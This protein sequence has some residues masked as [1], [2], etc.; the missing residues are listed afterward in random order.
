VRIGDT[1]MQT[2]TVRN[3]GNGPIRF[4]EVMVTDPGFATGASTCARLAPQEMCT[5]N[6]L[7][8]PTSAGEMVGY[9]RFTSNRGVDSVGL[10]GRGVKKRQHLSQKL[11]KR[12]KVLGLTPLTPANART[13]AGQP[14]QTMGRGGPLQPRAAG[15]VRYFRM[16]R[17][18]HGKTGIRTFGHADLKIVI[19]QRAKGT[20]QYRPFE[21]RVVYINGVRR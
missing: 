3:S 6:V 9:L 21:R 1:K 8:T 12:I 13:D 19:I 10:A 14:I 18:P 4:D 16:V 5:V 7:F 2:V 20:A 17:G 11:P 15:Q